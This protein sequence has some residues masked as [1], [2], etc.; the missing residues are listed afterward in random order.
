MIQKALTKPTLMMNIEKQSMA[1]SN[2]GLHSLSQSRTFCRR[3]GVALSE[4][5]IVIVIISF[6]ALLLLSRM[7]RG[8][9]QSR[10]LICLSNLNQIG[11]ACAFYTQATGQYP[12]TMAWGT[13]EA[14][15]ETSVLWNL[16][17]TLQFRDFTDVESRIESKKAGGDKTL[18][19]FAVGLR[20]PSDRIMEP[21]TATNYRANTG[22]DSNGGTGPFGISQ[23]V[24]PK[25]V[26]A[27][28]GSAFTAAFAERLIGNG[29][30]E[31]G[32]SN[33]QET[34]DCAKAIAA[35]LSEDPAVIWKGDA[36]Y[37]WSRGDWSQTLYHHGLTP[38]WKLSAVANEGN[39]G[40]MGSSSAHPGSVHVLLLDGSAKSWRET[41]D[42]L[43][44]RRLGGYQDGQVNE[45]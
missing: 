27:G 14:G 25:Q 19:P 26:E 8:R 37:D 5:V 45:K 21:R 33:Y 22:V 34:Q 23:V 24:T 44:W 4:V 40:Q 42:R 15:R 39:C 9:E 43:V 3:R 32:I 18:P 35:S 31:M 16:R 13:G 20:C 10:S 12:A 6:T 7:P 30:A 38:N 36:G 11:Q 29:K 1:S 41:V 28:D 17:A 2:F